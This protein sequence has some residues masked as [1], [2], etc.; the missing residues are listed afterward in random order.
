M[1]DLPNIFMTLL[2]AWSNGRKKQ[3]DALRRHICASDF[4]MQVSG[5]SSKPWGIRRKGRNA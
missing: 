1:R 4:I 2:S 5:V 3:R